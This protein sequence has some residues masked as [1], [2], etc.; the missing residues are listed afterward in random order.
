MGEESKP[1]F[2]FG[3]YRLD[4]MERVLMRDGRPVPLAPKTFDLLL[5]LV[6]RHGHLVE[7]ERLLQLVWPD[8]V[9]EESNLSYNVSILRKTLGDGEGARLIETVPKRGYRFVAPVR[10]RPAG[11]DPNRRNR[12]WV[13]AGL[14]LAAL[15]GAAAW[16]MGSGRDRS[17]PLLE[18]TP[19]TTYAGSE[20]YPDLSPDGN[21]VA[22]SWNGAAEG[23][24][25]IYVQQ[26]GSSVPV[27][28]TAG[29]GDDLSPVW[30]PDGR[31]ACISP[32]GPGPPAPPACTFC[33]FRAAPSANS[34]TCCTSGRIW[35]TVMAPRSPGIRM[36]NG[37]SSRIGRTPSES[38]ALCLISTSTR[39]E[40]HAAASAGH[41]RRRHRGGGSPRRQIPAVYQGKGLRQDRSIWCIPVRYGDAGGHTHRADFPCGLSNGQSRL[42]SGR[43]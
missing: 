21:Q 11:P 4:A 23:N 41:A 16:L 37:W 12:R 33:H 38:P 43:K 7:K 15:A 31:S 39:R 17:E 14:A 40:T 29:P 25:R 35:K 2:E 9:V 5:V 19:V 13:S 27:P 18:S 42:E 22:F 10:M 28:L 6:E 24:Y 36:G 1:V 26:L 30:S 34:S 20:L 8:T 32:R 3:P